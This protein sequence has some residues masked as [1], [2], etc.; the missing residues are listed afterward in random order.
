MEHQEVDLAQV[1]AFREEKAAIQRDFMAA[2]SEKTVASLGMNV[3]GPVKTG[4]LLA[5][6]FQEGMSFLEQTFE[7][8]GGSVIRKSVLEQSA[9]YA[10]VWLIEGIDRYHLKK[11]S[12]RMETAHPIGRLFDV[13]VMDEFG[14]PL[15]RSAVGA[16]QRTCF[17]CGKDAKICGRSRT[18]SVKEL[19]QKVEEMLTQWK[20]GKKD[21]M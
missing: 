1:L 4:P 14:E 19:Q 5:E 9:G 6:A 21:E 20:V 2:G 10:A 16:A 17:L 15:S 12:V 13:D 3:P 8:Q 18:H 11:E 7:D